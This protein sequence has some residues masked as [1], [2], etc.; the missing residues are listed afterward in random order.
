MGYTGTKELTEKYEVLKTQFG[1]NDT[2]SQVFQQVHIHDVLTVTLL[3]CGERGHK[4]HCTITQLYFNS[5]ANVIH[6]LE[7]SHLRSLH[8]ITMHSTAQSGV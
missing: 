1:D 6:F 8:I 4:R 5:S 3:M 2:F 7:F